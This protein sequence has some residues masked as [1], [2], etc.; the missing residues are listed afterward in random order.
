VIGAA[1][2]SPLGEVFRLVNLVNQ[3][4]GAGSNWAK[5]H[6]TKANTIFSKSTYCQAVFVV[7]SEPRAGVRPS[8]RACVRRPSLLAVLIATRRC[9][10]FGVR[11]R[12]RKARL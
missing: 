6:C 1:C 4:A 9:W 2:A 10:A 3:N 5:A 8:V 11:V 12:V 7:N